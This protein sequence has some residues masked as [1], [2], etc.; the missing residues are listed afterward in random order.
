MGFLMDLKYEE[1]RYMIE[2]VCFMGYYPTHITIVG[3]MRQ[4]AGFGVHFQTQMRRKHEE[5]MILMLNN[6]EYSHGK[7]E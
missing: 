4:T 3:K 6:V 7:I 5:F 1:L 2:W